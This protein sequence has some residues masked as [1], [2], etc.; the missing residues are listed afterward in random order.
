M[1]GFNLKDEKF[2]VIPVFV[3]VTSCYIPNNVGWVDEKLRLASA[4]KRNNVF[5]IWKMIA[6]AIQNTW[7]R[8]L[9][10]GYTDFTSYH[11]SYWVK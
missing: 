7:I 8:V 10:T 5:K 11:T 1:L 4:R 6:Y 3:D 2:I 9:H